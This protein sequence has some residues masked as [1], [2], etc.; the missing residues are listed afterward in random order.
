MFKQ[1]KMTA[2]ETRDRGV[3]KAN[4]AQNAGPQ[5][6]Y[7]APREAAYGPIDEDELRRQHLLNQ[8]LDIS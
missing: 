5:R 7:S 2:Q 6:H 1:G 3:V 4:G 8:S